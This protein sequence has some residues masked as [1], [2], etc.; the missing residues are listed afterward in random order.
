LGAG[1]PCRPRT[2]ELVAEAHAV[3]L[4]VHPYT[5]RMDRLPEGCGAFEDLL[6][7]FIDD[8]K[9]DGLFTDFPDLA[10]RYLTTCRA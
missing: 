3:G 2:T 10:V 8:L 7:T 5:F 1:P 6:H 4:L 9:V